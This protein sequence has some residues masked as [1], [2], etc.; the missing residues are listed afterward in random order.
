VISGEAI[1]NKQFSLQP[2]LA[3][4]L[5]YHEDFLQIALQNEPVL[6]S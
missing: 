6:E 2:I 1:A 4:D 3:D 5:L